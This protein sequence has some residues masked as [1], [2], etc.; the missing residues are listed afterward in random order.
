MKKLL[1]LSLLI[2]PSVFAKQIILDIP[3]KDIKIVETDIPDAEEWVRSL[4]SNK[5]KNCSSRIIESETKRSRIE[6]QSIPA[7]DAAIIDKAFARPD[8]KS[9]KEQE[10]NDAATKAK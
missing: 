9:R 3:D 4:W 7:G 1:F 6:V 5:L 10:I 8:Y 2:S